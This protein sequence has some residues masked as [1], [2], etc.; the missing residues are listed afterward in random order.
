MDLFE[1]LFI[2]LFIIFPIMEGVLRKRKKGQEGQQGPP[3]ED[4]EAGTADTGRESREP[5]SEMLPDDL[6][7]LMTGER[8]TPRSEESAGREGAAEPEEAPW[9]VDPESSPTVTEAEIETETED[10]RSEPWVVDEEAN[11]REPASLE[12]EGPEAYSLET[13]APEPIERKVPTAAARHRAFHELVDRP[14]RRPARKLSPLMRALRS[15][16]GLRQAVLLKEILGP[17]KG[18]Q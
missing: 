17:P 8:R 7:E 12:Y 6:W 11:A 18:L 16:D 5:A 2:A 1:L 4:Q 15:P 14:K 13:P 3:I 10:W 9:S